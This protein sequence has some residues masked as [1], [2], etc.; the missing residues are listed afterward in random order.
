MPSHPLKLVLGGG[1]QMRREEGKERGEIEGGEVEEGE[2]EGGEM[3]GGEI[4]GGE[5]R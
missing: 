2:V 5:E 3:E 1:S 4:E